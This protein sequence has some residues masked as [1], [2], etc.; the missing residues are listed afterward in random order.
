[1]APTVAT[2]PD[3]ALP[4][5]PTGTSVGARPKPGG[6]AAAHAS[7]KYRP[8]VDGL[9]A[10]AV[11]AVVI[12]HLGVR[13]AHGGFVGV[14]VF[15]VISGYL[16]GSIILTQIG[17]GTFTFSSFYER[18]IRR[19]LPAVMAMLL[20]VSPLAYRWL[21]P[22]ELADYARSLLSANFS[23]SNFYFWQQSGYFDNPTSKPL[24]HTWS[25]GVEEQFY[26]ALPILLVLLKRLVP[27]RTA[28]WLGAL[29]A[30]SVAVS[31]V[32]VYRF[33]TAAFYL[34]PSRAWEL[35][36]G[37]IMSLEGFP[38][39]R[40][41][42]ARQT[43][44]LVGLAMVLGPCLVYQ[45]STP[46]PGLAALVPC[47]G[48]GLIIAAGRDG[49]NLVGRLLSLPPAVFIGRI[50]YS[51]YLWHWPII[52]FSGMGMTLIKGLTQHQTQ[53]FLL[54][55]S[56]AAATLS[57]RFV[58]GPFR[59][60]RAGVPPRAVFRVAATAIAG[61]AIFG[62]ALWLSH[63]LPGRFPAD[64][65]KVA[66]YLE[67]DSGDAGHDFY[68]HGKCFM[69]D[70]DWDLQRFDPRECLAQVPG[71]PTYLILG[72]SHA[73]HLWWGLNKAYPD[74]SVMQATATG[75]K[76]VLHQ[77]PR[78]HPGCTRLMT[79]ILGDYLVH[80]HVDALWLEGRWEAD[81]LPS[82]AATLDWLR[83][84]QVRVT[85]FGPMLQYDSPLP[86]LLAMSLRDGDPSIPVAHLIPAFW[87]LDDRMA[88]LARNTWKVPYVSMIRLLCKGRDCLQYAGAG[89]PLQSDYGHL[90]EDGSVRVA[91]M[92]RDEAHLQ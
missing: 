21:L 71:K 81:D 51:L 40:S 62:G 60:R 39:L 17:A 53:L 77:R 9:R 2:E 4:A 54:A 12:F 68:R 82:L 16:I 11:L 10:L 34:L 28:V 57:W 56:I 49:P 42:A 48:A 66:S 6:A 85:L 72:D 46:F 18:R 38:R 25:L 13:P 61:V 8:D 35:L 90:T 14:D 23:I 70:L 92:L 83:A 45:S 55:L 19:I 30:A 89:V 29:G 91:K 36:L 80:H 79:Y 74:A 41:A 75:C 5:P 63:G 88:A 43:A 15:F 44:G 73:A 3:D 20:A 31:A 27:R 33:P 26:I 52:V 58:E 65:Q 67:G 76:P 64:A 86:R 24:L 47:V 32:G 50:S 69:T 7:L 78:Q 1:M 37:T 87:S 59:P 84:H 22:K